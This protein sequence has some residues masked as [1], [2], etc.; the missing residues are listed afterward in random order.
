LI[1]PTKSPR[2]A[3]Q[4]VHKILDTANLAQTPSKVIARDGNPGHEIICPRKFA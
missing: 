3:R 1:E 4:A 2:K